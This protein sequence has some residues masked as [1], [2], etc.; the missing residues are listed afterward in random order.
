MGLPPVLRRSLH[1]CDPLLTSHREASLLCSH[2]GGTPA[3][4]AAGDSVHSS[5]LVVHTAETPGGQAERARSSHASASLIQI[6]KEVRNTRLES[7]VLRCAVHRAQYSFGTEL[8][9]SWIRSAR[10]LLC[11]LL[12]SAASI[13]NDHQVTLGTFREA[14]RCPKA[15]NWALRR[16]GTRAHLGPRLRWARYRKESLATQLKGNPGLLWHVCSVK[17]GSRART[18]GQW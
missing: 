3:A 6:C 12:S 14:G 11:V 2:G 7:T 18:R 5:S 8:T 15:Q 17:L 1:S 4:R 16:K 10:A 9:H 13:H